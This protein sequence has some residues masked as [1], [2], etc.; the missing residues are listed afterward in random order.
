MLRAG[1][2]AR[3]DASHDDE[4]AGVDGAAAKRARVEGAAGSGAPLAA[5][6]SG[7]AAG[8]GG[9]PRAAAAAPR[10]CAAGLARFLPSEL[11]EVY[12]TLLL[13]AE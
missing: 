12:R 8:G 2:A 1:G 6:G 5:V 13:P 3:S 11:R 9:A 10:D 4:M 7:T